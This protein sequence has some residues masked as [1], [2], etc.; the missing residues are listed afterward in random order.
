[1]DCERVC[2]LLDD[3][4]C[5]AYQLAAVRELAAHT[6]VEIPLVVINDETFRLREQSP[7]YLVRR[8][9]SWGTWAPVCGATAVSRAIRGPPSYDERYHYSTVNALDDAAVVRCSPHWEDDRWRSLPGPVIDTITAETDVA[10]RFGFGLLTGRILEALEYGVLSFH[11]GDIREYRGRIG[12]VWEYL[13][14]EPSAG[15]T[16]QQ[17]TRRVDGG[18]I[19]AVDDVPIGPRDTYGAVKRR[20]RSIL[21]E[22]LVEG[23]QKLNEPGFEPMVPESLG[24]YRSSPT[25]RELGR[26]LRKNGTNVVRRAVAGNFVTGNKTRSHQNETQSHH[27]DDSS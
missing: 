12:T 18:R 22:L 21:G 15:V 4:C 5:P 6:T 25:V 1:M 16:L 17:L 27:V 14:D 13:A 19:V 10:V 23:L 7:A 26:F 2:L 9:R 11:F 20:Q 8:L 24:P 3:E